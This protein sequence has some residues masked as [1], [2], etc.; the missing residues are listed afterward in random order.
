MSQSNTKHT[1]VYEVNLTIEKPVFI[2]NEAWLIAHFKE[3]VTENNFIKLRL[4]MDRNPNPID[5][6]HLRYQ[7]II[8]QYYVAGYDALKTYFEEQAKKMRSQVSD[9]LGHH[10]TVSRRVFELVSCFDNEDYQS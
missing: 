2:E 7:K 1:F 10:Y 3:M 9:R 8:A 4:F 5:D 6:T